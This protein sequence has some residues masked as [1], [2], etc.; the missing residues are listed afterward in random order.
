MRFIKLVCGACNHPILIQ[1]GKSLLKSGSDNCQSTIRRWFSA[2]GN[3]DSLPIRKHVQCISVNKNL[4]F[5]IRIDHGDLFMSRRQSMHMTLVKPTNRSWPSDREII[6]YFHAIHNYEQWL[7]L[8]YSTRSM[9]PFRLWNSC[10]AFNIFREL[11]L[12]HSHGFIQF[13]RRTSLRIWF[14]LFLFSSGFWLT[15]CQLPIYD[16]V[17]SINWSST[18]WR[19]E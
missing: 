4:N 1:N 7:S 19:N 11:L 10:E 14:I 9:F 13:N 6:M 15:R 3:R 12:L 18:I 17:A 8:A 16:I 2:F 5:L